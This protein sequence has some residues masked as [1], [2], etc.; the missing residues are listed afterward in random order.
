MGRHIFNNHSIDY[1]DDIIANGDTSNNLG[2]CFD[3][4]IVA[5]GRAVDLIAITDS[6]L[7]VNPTILTNVSARNNGREA[8]LDKEPTFNISAIDIKIEGVE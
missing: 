1:Y 3:V 5:N 6:Y 4:D 8:M 2:S 7:L